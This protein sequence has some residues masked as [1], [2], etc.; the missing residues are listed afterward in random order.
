[1]VLYPNAYF[2]FT[3]ILFYVKAVNKV[4]H[5]TQYVTKPQGILPNRLITA[6]CGLEMS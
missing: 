6:A 3:R 1:M 2:L 4:K 5:I